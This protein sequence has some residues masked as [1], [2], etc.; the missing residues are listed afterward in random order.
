MAGQ[1]GGEID[2]AGPLGAV[3]APNGLGH[4]W[5]H[6][7]GLAAVTPAWRHRQRQPGAF[8]REFFRARGG[9]GH[10]A[11]AGVGNDA[12]HPLAVGMAQRS[13]M[14]LATDLARFMVCVS[15]DSR[16]PPRRPSMAGRMPILGSVLNSGF[17]MIL[18]VDFMVFS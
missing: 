3:E 6:V 1:H 8:A 5:V 14:S 12:F 13:P 16:T 15:S 10:S 7:H 17:S 2:R 18:R 4:R 11:D 9:L